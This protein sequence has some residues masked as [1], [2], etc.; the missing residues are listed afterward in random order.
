MTDPRS[1]RVLVIINGIERA[2]ASGPIR[3][4]ILIGLLLAV[5]SPLTAAHSQRILSALAGDG[6][7]Q[8]LETALP[9][10]SWREANAQWVK[11]LMQ[12]M[13]VAVIIVS[14]TS[15]VADLTRGSLLLVLT[16]DVSRR[17]FLTS[18]VLGLHASLLIVSVGGACAAWA[19]TLL[20]FGDGSFAAV[21]GAS[22][23][24]FLQASVVVGAAVLAAVVSPRVA[25]SAGA[26]FGAYLL[27]VVGSM[28]SAAAKTSPV[29]LP[30]LMEDLAS[31][32]GMGEGAWA[33]VASSA[34]VVGA[35][36]IVSLRV[37]DGRDLG[38]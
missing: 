20:V 38:G 5:A 14:A 24:W 35:C 11:N 10:P 1:T 6:L 7:A 26:A 36:L 15:I 25:S 27:I 28:W 9:D 32:A 18:R 21:L 30:L 3:F 8:V 29:G 23:A 31:G 22:L 2:L 13:S 37:F 33:V 16:R 34:A 19:V 17:A 4:L 12:I